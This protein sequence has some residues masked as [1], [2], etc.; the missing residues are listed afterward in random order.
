MLD[1]SAYVHF[2][3]LCGSVCVLC[4]PRALASYCLQ[5]LSRI[6]AA[7][8]IVEEERTMRYYTLLLS[9]FLIIFILVQTMFDYL[10]KKFPKSCR[11]A[12]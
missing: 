7:M 8:L 9:F 5:L 3:S 12:Y 2:L 11:V 6:N 1:F 10:K 4:I